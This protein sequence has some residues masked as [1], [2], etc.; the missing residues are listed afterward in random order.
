ME[1]MVLAKRAIDADAGKRIAP[2]VE[3]LTE[4]RKY[5]LRVER[6]EWRGLSGE[7]RVKRLEDWRGQSGQ[8]RIER[9]EWRG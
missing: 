3:D 4:V 1:G 9:P 7:A 8:A 6:L 5:S 2:L